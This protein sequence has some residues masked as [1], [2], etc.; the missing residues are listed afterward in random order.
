MASPNDDCIFPL[1]RQIFRGTNVPDPG[2]LSRLQPAPSWR[3][4]GAHQ[5]DVAEHRGKTYQASPHERDMV[6]AAL[7]LRRPL[8]IEGPPGVGKSSLAHAVAYELAL[9]PVLVWPITSRS[10]R[11]QGLYGYD[12][13]ARF[14]DIAL[15]AKRLELQRLRQGATTADAPEPDDTPVDD[16]QA[17]PSIG[18]YLRLGPL[19]TAFLRSQPL[20]PSV[21]LIDELDKSNIDLPN[22]LLHLFE[23][24]YFEIPEIARLGASGRDRAVDQS[25]PIGMSTVDNPGLGTPQAP[26]E[27]EPVWVMPHDGG[28][29]IAVPA[30]GIVRCPAFPLVIMTS[31]GERDFP[32]AFLRRCLRLTIQKPAPEKLRRIAKEHLHF[33]I[34][35]RASDAG[36]ARDHQTVTLLEQFT[37]LRDTENKA[38]ATDQL[39]NALYLINEGIDL[40]SAAAE[41][42][43]N[44]ILAVLTAG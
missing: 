23:D 25:H 7:Y 29:G 36:P 1:T 26:E 31:N 44:D 3:P 13:V 15:A 18:R 12:A 35:E 40:S 38:V 11:E 28:P 41:R 4:F 30:T 5:V 27:A 32:P 22:D 43:R 14:Q 39:L 21:V 33:E 42:L 37:R 34:P 17:L 8:L 2:A 10:T 20:R 6:N 16:P 9:D 24:A 19:G